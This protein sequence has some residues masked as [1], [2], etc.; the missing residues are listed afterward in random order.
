MICSKTDQ[1]FGR[2][3]ACEDD[4]PAAVEQCTRVFHQ[5]C[6]ALP[7]HRFCTSLVQCSHHIKAESE[8]FSSIE[9][10]VFSL[11]FFLLLLICPQILRFEQRC[12]W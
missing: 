6:A 9:R 3:A 1:R 12:P 7:N 5:G 11:F 10:F 2:L 4:G 8:K